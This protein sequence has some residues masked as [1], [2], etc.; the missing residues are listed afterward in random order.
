MRSSEVM[1]IVRERRD[2]KDAAA[3][4]EAGELY[5][6]DEDGAREIEDI[7]AGRHPLQHGGRNLDA[8]GNFEAKLTSIRARRGA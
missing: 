4:L 8:W 2:P 3:L 7:Q 6:D 5:A 1:Q